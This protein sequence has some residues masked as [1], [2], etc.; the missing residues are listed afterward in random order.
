MKSQDLAEHVQII[1]DAA[2]NRILGV[3][4]E[5]YSFGEEQR[6]EGLPLTT[7]FDWMQEELQDVVSY[8]TMLSIRIERVRKALRS[9]GMMEGEQ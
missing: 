1:A 7:L 6:F 4:N 2:K 5:Q 3:G 8:A 9:T